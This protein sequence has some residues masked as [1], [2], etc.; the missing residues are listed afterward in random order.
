MLFGKPKEQMR[1]V[2]YVTHITRKIAF[3]N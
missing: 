3:K 2:G 1:L